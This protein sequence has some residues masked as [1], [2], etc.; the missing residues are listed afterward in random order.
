MTSKWMASVAMIALLAPMGAAR[1]QSADIPALQAQTE[2]LKA[3]NLEL[4]QRLEQAGGPAAGPAAQG[5]VAQPRRLRPF[6]GHGHQGTA[7]GVTD[8]GPICWQGVCI[9]G[10]VDAG[11]GWVSHGLP[12]N[13]KNY[14]GESLINKFGN[15]PYFGIAQNGLSAVHARHQGRNE[16]LPGGSG[17]FM[18]STGINP[19]SGQ[20]ADM[21]GTM[22]ANQGLNRNPYSFIG[23]GGR[24]GQPSTISSTPVVAPRIS[25]S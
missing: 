22:V 13:G 14:E 23:D 2:A 18:A 6:H 17:V 10:A 25:A 4:E 19:Q 9:F 5:P 20:F 11:V 8:E 15:R 16:F 3:Q 1:A 7:G 21:P 24:G 12:E